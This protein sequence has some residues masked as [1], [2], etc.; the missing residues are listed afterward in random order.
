LAD[1]LSLYPTDFV[2]LHNPEAQPVALGGLYL[3]DNMVGWPTQHVLA[4]LSFIGGNG[5][6]S[7]KADA[8]PEQGA[9]HLSFRLA[10]EQGLV[11][12]LAP[13]QSVVDCVYYGPQ[14]TDVSEGRT[15][16]GA[17]T[18]DF[19]LQPT[20]GLPN[21][22]VTSG[23][24]SSTNVL[25]AFTNVWR[26]SQTEDLTAVNWTA[27]N[28]TDGGWPAGPALLA[29]DPDTLPVPK[30][31]L[32]TL[33]R[34]TYYFRTHFR[35]NGDPAQ[36]NLRLSAMVDDGA[37]FYL[38]GQRAYR[39]GM[40]DQATYSYG[41]LANRNVNNAVLEGPFP[42]PAT[43]L[44]A[45]DNV[46]AVEVHQYSTSS[47]DIALGATLES[48][49]SVTNV[50]PMPVVLS[51][52]L[53]NNVSLTN[54]NGLVRDW[55][56]L[57]NPSASA[58][59]LAD[60]S[61]SDDLDNPRKWV[62]PTGASI[63]ANSYL[64]IACD[65]QAAPSDTNTGFGLGAGGGGV[66]FFNRTT[67]SQAWVDGVTYGMQAA[68]FSLGRAGG[69][70]GNWSLTRPTPGAANAM[71]TLGTPVTVRINEWMASPAE[72]DDWFELHNPGSAPVELSG[73]ALT[74][75]LANR[76]KSPVP[77]LSFI[78]V[79]EGAFCK[80]IADGSTGKGTDHVAFSLAG[81]G[82]RIGLFTATGTQID[83]V[84]FGAQTTGVS[85][86][87]FPDGSAN[88][89]TFPETPSPEASNFLPVANVLINE[90]LSHTDPPLEDAIEFY[91]PS[92]SAVD[93]S[94]WY[95]SNTERDLRRFRIP[96]NTIVPA[97][98][99]KVLYEY[100]FGNPAGPG[101]LVPFTFNSAHGDT[102]CLTPTNGVGDLSAYRARVRFGAATNGVS[103]GRYRDSTGRAH[104]VAQSRRTF[105]VDAPN[106]VAEFRAG[107]GGTNAYPLVGPVVI[108][109]IMY[110]PP[111]GGV[112]DNTL[113]EY[114]EL[115]NIS[116][117]PVIFFDPNAATNT[118]HIDGGV[119]FEF[120]AFTTLNA[121][122]YLV[123]VSFDPNQDLATLAAFRTRYGLT[124]TT[125][126]YGPY[127]GQLGNS[128]ER[129]SL[130]KPDPPQAPP[131]PD[132]G[133]V[134]YVLVEQVDYSALPPWPTNATGSGMSLQRRG[135]GEFGNDPANWRAAAPTAGKAN[136]NSVD[137]ADG[138]GLLDA[139]EIQYF[140]TIDAPNAA[141]DLDVDLDGMTNREEF[142][143]G[144]DPTD[145]A[146]ALLLYSELDVWGAVQLRFTAVAGKSYTIEYRSAMTPGAWQK[147]ADVEP[148]GVTSEVHLPAG[149]GPETE[150]YYR[151][152]T[153]KQP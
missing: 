149:A 89:V 144:T 109:E 98:G 67:A 40:P 10:A 74:D 99:F 13:D 54:A 104:F 150:R 83:A 147:L 3:T 14:R 140:G 63:P 36:A 32:L 105:G 68:D 110:A 107:T 84:T 77:A 69:P 123:L 85:Q 12:L 44:L 31:T 24:V 62:F 26:Y 94:G 70:Q 124:S 5:Y 22:L 92:A 19:F 143:A 66:Y 28:Y 151:L 117:A 56:E 82:E 59:D 51:E 35:F 34:T 23:I 114:L 95:L 18:I 145:A 133:F 115:R 6:R 11:A 90:L 129:L 57:F 7:F 118:W 81:G 9:D 80:F 148:A 153:P 111:N 102:A 93:L 42:L 152:I 97:G 25:I 137:D 91:N 50:G 43:N 8:D 141:P 112:P 48:V 64:V 113:D 17:N 53:A 116:S 16:N 101:V 21:P 47:G 46:L 2:E 134:P 39:L 132:A 65:G 79:G 136:A 33:G 139:W 75:D 1:E 76:N 55:V 4:P 121:G 88:L 125:A 103:F 100:Q 128:G 27:T 122:E 127:Q 61:L 58:V 120:P 78:G 72:G 142:L 20:P 96:D 135:G 52:V 30:N 49:T 29:Y 106:S 37:V 119:E 131:S 71:V 126:I 138:D 15:P 87:R 86:G 45:G 41:D 130:W 38:N 146:S 60:M 73:L 108:N